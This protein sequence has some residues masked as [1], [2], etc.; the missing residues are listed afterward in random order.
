MGLI[1]LVLWGLEGGPYVSS[2]IGPPGPISLGIWGPEGP[3]NRE[4]HFA[5]T[6][7]PGVALSYQR[8]YC[9]GTYIHSDNA[10]VYKHAYTL[11]IMHHGAFIIKVTVF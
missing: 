3:K 4:P 10:Y 2:D 5:A 7:G 11:R 6:L 1:S 9:T 8:V